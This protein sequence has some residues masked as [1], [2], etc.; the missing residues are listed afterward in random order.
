MKVLIVD[1][2]ISQH[3]TL[4]LVLRSRGYQVTACPDC[5]TAWQAYQE[6]PCELLFLDW[7][8]STEEKQHLLQQ[9]R[10]LTSPNPVTVA[11]LAA[12]TPST[13]LQAALDAGTDDYILQPISTESLQLRLTV[14]EKRICTSANAPTRRPILS[15][16]T[17]VPSRFDQHTVP[18][19]HH[20]TAALQQFP[21]IASHH[22]RQSL[23]QVKKQ[24]TELLGQ[25]ERAELHPHATQQL[26]G[27]LDRASFMQQLVSDVLIDTWKDRSDTILKPRRQNYMILD[28][29]LRI[30]EY[31]RDI[32]QFA[33]WS[34]AIAIGQDIRRGF[35]EFVGLEDLL[36]TI[37]DEQQEHFELSGIARSTQNNPNLF[38][39]LEIVRYQHTTHH[40]PC[41]MV[42]VNDATERMIFQKR[43]VQSANQAE[44][45]L[46]RLTCTKDY[47]EKI[48]NSMADALIVTNRAGKIET[49]N[50]ATE[51]LFGYRQDELITQPISQ[52]IAQEK[53][54]IEAARANHNV[55]IEIVCQK[56][57]GET[58]T[59]SFSCAAIE[60][61][62]ETENFIFV[63]RDVTQEKQAKAQ[64]QQLN[65]SLRRR[66]QELET[67]NRDL[68]AFSRNVAHDLRAPISHIE[69][70]RQ[71]LEEEYA[72]QLEGEGIDYLQQIAN[73]CQRMGQLIKDLLQLSQVNRTEM[74]VVPIDLSAIARYIA[75]GLQEQS[76]ERQVEF[77]IAPNT[78]LYGSPGLLKVVLDNLMGNAWKYSSKRAIA[79]I[80]FGIDSKLDNG[81]NPI[82]FVRDNGAG[83]DM[84]HAHKL[85]RAFGR[86]H[87][88]SE[89]EGTGVGL[90]LVQRIIERHGGRI[91]AEGERDRGA[92]FY[93]TIP[94]S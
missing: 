68:E 10:D 90:A 9:I 15:L 78:E 24:L 13:E 67:A 16:V 85:F 29:Q 27:I 70:F 76:P 34:E 65:V 46:R 89:F 28:P 48:V 33:E 60:T 56:K 20:K 79:K 63:G 23:V 64:I 4:T 40:N 88:Q 54:L 14:L 1:A 30:L 17:A 26:Q 92:T 57:T 50:L 83:F 82:Y 81:K 25:A 31:S 87:S 55:K 22:L 21:Y 35:P 58:L 66:T 39:D 84:N 62:E 11:I 49:L 36:A 86:L 69:F 7:Q 38:F 80:E 32:K 93:F 6:R 12:T 3:N 91:W 59:V 19:V 51:T 75:T 41:L 53:S 43:L 45:L 8:Q 37:L 72:E 18:S 73:S 5:Q 74:T 42:L 44:L 77:T 52:L 61:E 47:T 71:A 94:M 2:K